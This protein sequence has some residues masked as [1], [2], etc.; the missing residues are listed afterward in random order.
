MNF[1]FV[2]DPCEEIRVN[3]FHRLN[4]N[5][6]LEADREIVNFY[7][8]YK[9]RWKIMNNDKYTDKR[10]TIYALKRNQF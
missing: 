4:E 8:D 1:I 3:L 10:N 2:N 5:Q 9:F 6:K 7:K